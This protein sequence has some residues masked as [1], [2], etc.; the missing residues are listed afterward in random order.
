MRRLIVVVDLGHAADSL[1]LV[2]QRDIDF[3]VSTLLPVIGPGCRRGGS[4]G[5]GRRKPGI[6]LVETVDRIDVL[7]VGKLLRTDVRCK[8][9]EQQE[10]SEHESVEMRIMLRMDRVGEERREGRV[11]V[12]G[13]LVTCIM[14]RWIRRLDCGHVLMV[15][16]IAEST[17]RRMGD[18]TSSR[19]LNDR[20]VASW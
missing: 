13:T 12:R 16:A 10:R 9:A 14:S 18:S 20:P 2:V 3:V 11:L 7:C 1:V 5:V 8:A 19:P 6:N 17:R 15:N 4:L